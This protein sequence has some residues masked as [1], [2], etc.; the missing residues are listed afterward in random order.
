MANSCE[1]CRGSKTVRDHSSPSWMF[2]KRVS[3]PHCGGSGIEPAP[4]C[5]SS[6]KPPTG[7]VEV[8]YPKRDGTMMRVV[9]PDGK[10]SLSDPDVRAAVASGH[11]TIIKHPHDRGPSEPK[12]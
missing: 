3:C 6:A 11:L 2:W 5:A 8:V 1:Q 7:A 9:L 12:G 4:R 10:L